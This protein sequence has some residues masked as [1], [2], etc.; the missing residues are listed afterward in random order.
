MPHSS[1]NGKA[2]IRRIVSLLRHDRILDV[3]VG[4]GV[5]AD[6]FPK[7]EL[8]GVEIFLPYVEKFK[9]LSKYKEILIDDVRTRECFDTFD[10]AIAGDVLEHMEPED[11]AAVVRKLR[12]CADVVIASIPLGH[13]PQGEVDGNPHEAHIGGDWSVQ[14]VAEVLGAP[15]YSK[16]CHEIGIFVW[17]GFDN[18]VLTQE[19]L[20][21]KPKIAVY[22]ISKNEEQFVERFMASAKDADLVLIADTGSEDG[23]VRKALNLGAAVPSICVTPWRF[24]L[25]R[26]AALALIPR[27][28]DICISLDLDEVLEPGWREE[29]EAV[30]EADTTRLEYYFDWGAGLKFLYQKIHARHG[31]R[32]HHPV[33]EYPVPDGRI[34]EVW[35]H[36][37]KL[38]VSHHPDNTKSRGQY[39]PLLELAVKEDPNC[40][41]NA[42][43]HARELTFHGRWPEAVAALEAYLKMPSATWENERCYAMRLLGKAHSE[44]GTPW[45]AEKWYLRAA[46]EAPGT[47]EPWCELAMLYYMQRRWE[48]CFS[49]SMRAL[50]IKDKQLVYTCDP[51]VWGHW[52]HDLASIAAW[53][54]GL[55]EIAV[56]QA[57][58]ALAASP[59]DARL[60]ANL[61]FV[62]RETLATTPGGP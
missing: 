54:M 58:L 26:N 56:E 12:G 45:L 7:A 55:K 49:V 38:L 29:I 39:M 13:M 5:Y 35:A 44:L 53:H 47:R 15:L 1:R 3:G 61:D 20:V 60:K 17:P 32:W 40:P 8:T 28:I 34:T 30:W 16:V 50:S 6:M 27:D 62:S 25:A 10:V 14:R 48:D 22:A 57:K 36:S 46:A 41:R 33:H 24:D 52:A 4:S 59:E 51:A 19:M 9:L 2:E 42:F 21:W 23:T 18:R 37:G 43:Y 31:Y 11:A